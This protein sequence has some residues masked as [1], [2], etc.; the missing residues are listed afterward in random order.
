M[1]DDTAWPEGATDEIGVGDNAPDRPWMC[2]LY[3]CMI[4]WW[5]MRF[6]VNEH[7]VRF[8]VRQDRCECGGRLGIHET[9]CPHLAAPEGRLF[10]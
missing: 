5:F 2:T 10:G 4:S 1:W 6:V 8:R 7:P 9:L 3:G